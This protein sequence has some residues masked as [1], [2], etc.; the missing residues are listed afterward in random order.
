[1]PAEHELLLL[2][3]LLLRLC[4]CSS[5]KWQQLLHAHLLPVL[6]LCSVPEGQLRVLLQD[7]DVV[8]LP[9]LLLLLHGT[10]MLGW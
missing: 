8:Q 1:M 5:S 7:A 4:W 6:L 2:P 10:G 9:R 3:L